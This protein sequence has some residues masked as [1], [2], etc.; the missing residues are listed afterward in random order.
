[1]F[2]LHIEVSLTKAS[3]NNHIHQSP[4]RGFFLTNKLLNNITL[5][6]SNKEYVG[7]IGESGAGK[8]TLLNI[9]STLDNPDKGE[10]LNYGKNI[11]GC[12]DIE[13]SKLRNGGH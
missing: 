5:T 1:M 7:I 13:I 10:I 4:F 9:L 3:S 11:K 2:N 6:V 8:S 12:S